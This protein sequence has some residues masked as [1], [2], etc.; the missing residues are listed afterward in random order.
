MASSDDKI[1]LAKYL[2][3][4]IY[5]LGTRSIMGVPG[6]M[7][8]ELLDYVDDANLKW[9]GS[10]NELNAAYAADG[11]CRVT[12]APG[13]LVTTMGVGKLSALNGVAGAYTEQ[14]KVVH[15]VGT[16]GTSVQQRRAIIYHCL[17][18]NPDHRVYEKISSHV[19]AAYCWLDDITKA[20]RAIDSVLRTCVT[21]SLPV[22]IFVPM[23]FVH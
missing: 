11:Y 17:G 22:Y 21:R 14:V 8:L 23:D 6:D 1:I 13:V 19:R 3:Q 10:A 16:T 15:I 7:K 5:Q 18:P 9:V 12:G 20:P 4:R 2:W